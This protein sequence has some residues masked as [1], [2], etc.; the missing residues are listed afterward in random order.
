MSFIALYFA[1]TLIKDT[2]NFDRLFHFASND[3][4]DLLPA[5][6]VDSYLVWSSKCQIPDLDP[7]DESIRKFITR[8]EPIV[9]STKPPLTFTT[10]V[11]DGAKHLLKIN[12]SAVPHYTVNQGNISCC[13]SVITRVNSQSGEK[14]SR[15]VDNHYSVSECSYFETE[16]I[17]SPE[18]EFILVHCFEVS[19]GGTKREVYKNSHAV[20]PLKETVE[21]KLNESSSEINSVEKRRLSILLMGFDSMSRLNLQRTMPK[22]VQHLQ[23]NGWLELL[24]YNKIGENTLPNVAA[25]LTGLSLDQMREQCWTSRF[26]KFDDCPFIWREFSK[27]GYVTAYSEDEPTGSTFNYHKTGFVV[28][29]TDYYIRPLLLA[30]EDILPVKKRHFLNVC[31]GPTPTTEHMFRHVTDIATVFKSALYFVVTWVNNFSHSSNS[32]PAAVDERVLLFFQE[33]EDTGALNT[34]FVV[35]LSDHGMRWG[36]IRS[37][38]IGWFEERLPFIYIWVPEW[39]K[40]KYSHFYDNLKTNRNRL[41]SPFDLHLTLRD[42]LEISRHDNT[43]RLPYECAGCPKCVSLFSEVPADRSCEDAGITPNWCT[44]DKYR[45]VS[46]KDKSAVAVA[47]YV[48]SEINAKLKKAGKGAALCAELTFDRILKM[49]RRVPVNSHDDFVVAFNTLPGGA[50]FEATVRRVKSALQLQG[51]VSRIST[52]GNSSDCVD[53]ADLKLYCYCT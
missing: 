38:S 31:L 37:T 18:K 4:D 12:I 8:A 43:T 50:V 34:T 29:P 23:L 26:K 35:F 16:V 24:G 45:S 7:F 14:Y 6:R 2:V 3:E 1:D 40:E 53:D 36:D 49:K 19:E 27:L 15:T 51:D 9:C 30:S 20:V 52:Y 21:L 32:I 11:P 48:L 41:T 44:C 42:I 33:L 39:F 13:Y 10:M 22:T 46:D 47:M 28:P 17:L 25:L 5:D